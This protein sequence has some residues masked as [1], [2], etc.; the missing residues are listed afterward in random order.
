MLQRQVGIEEHQ[1]LSEENIEQRVIEHDRSTPPLHHHVLLFSIVGKGRKERVHIVK[2]E[3]NTS[4]YLAH[5]D[6][7]FLAATN[8]Y[9]SI[10]T[11]T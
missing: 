11:L 7:K 2:A 4:I 1:E 5:S 6:V 8:E 9:D 10:H 3:K